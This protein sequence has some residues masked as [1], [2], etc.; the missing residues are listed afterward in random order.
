DRLGRALCRLPAPARVER[1]REHAEPRLRGTPRRRRPLDLLPLRT[2][3]GSRKNPPKPPPRRPRLIGRPSAFGPPLGGE[4]HGRLGKINGL[5]RNQR[6]GVRSPGLKRLA[7]LVRGEVRA[8]PRAFA[9]AALSGAL[10]ALPTLFA[11]CWPLA[12]VALVPYLL[13]FRPF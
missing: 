4:R 5:A 8:H 1:P 6:A 11:W 9:A 2:S 12:F 3:G 7:G 13:A 10:L